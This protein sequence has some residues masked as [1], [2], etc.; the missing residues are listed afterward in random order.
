VTRIAP[1]R[2]V[3]LREEEKVEGEWEFG[4]PVKVEGSAIVLGGSGDGIVDGR[5]GCKGCG[6]CECWDL[7][8][9]CGIWNIGC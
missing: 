2:Q 1:Q 4:S 9:T 3:E 5:S 7:K 8:K 6:L